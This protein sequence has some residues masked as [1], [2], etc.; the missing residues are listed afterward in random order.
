MTRRSTLK[1]AALTMLAGWLM[2][3]VLETEAMAARAGRG[4]SI[5]SRGSRTVQPPRRAPAPTPVQPAR[6]LQRETTAAAPPAQ[7]AP[8]PGGLFGGGFFRSM[9]GGLAGGFLG[10]M[11][12]RGLGGGLFG[13]GGGLF[14]GIGLLEILLVGGLIFLLFRLLRSRQAEPAPAIG[15]S[16]AGYSGAT[17]QAGG[18]EPAYDLYGRSPGAGVA[19]APSP[20]AEDL[21][22]GL[23][24]IRRMDDTFDEGR[25]KESCLDAFF[26]VQA[27]WSSRDL[28]AVHA[29]LT[30]EI[31]QEFETEFRRLRGERR[32]YRLENIAV[33]SCEITEAWQES[34]RDYITVHI[35][36]SL[37]DYTVDDATGHVVDGSRT[38]PVTFEEYW[39]FVRPV[40]RNMWQL[41]AIQ[42]PD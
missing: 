21:E 3:G 23:A 31:A 18:A 4:G 42:Q 12:F 36:A 25:F 9:A 17:Y 13:S 14:G 32:S 19:E 16:G 37:L 7:P 1:V 27:A 41:S 5:G 34:G 39:T 10:A 29:L 8:A 2:V 15:Y 6:P 35:K 38:E 11:L 33:R 20:D 24:R 28:A 40:G 30:E 22:R 26:K